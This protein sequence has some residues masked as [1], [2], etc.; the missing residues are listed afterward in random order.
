MCKGAIWCLWNALM[1]NIYESNV[2][3]NMLYIVLTIA[4]ECKMATLIWE[5]CTYFQPG[6]DWLSEIGPGGKL[7]VN[8]A[9]V[10][11]LPFP[12]TDLTK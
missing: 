4:A 12:V 6:S 7:L 5:Q 9:N 3:Y 8:M 2:F 10:M 1:C 11:C